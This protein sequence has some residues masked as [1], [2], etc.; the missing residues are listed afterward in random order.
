MFAPAACNPWAMAQAIER[1]LATPN[2]TAVRPLRSLNIGNSKSEVRSQNAEVYKLRA[3][4]CE[5]RATNRVSLNDLS[6][7]PKPV[8]SQERIGAAEGPCVVFALSSKLAAAVS[9]SAAD[10]TARSA[11]TGQ[12]ALPKAIASTT[13]LSRICSKVPKK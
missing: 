5:L 9:Q 11:L 3:S 8:R 13:R 7:R 6:S 2:T 1:L 10:A 4:S 12:Q